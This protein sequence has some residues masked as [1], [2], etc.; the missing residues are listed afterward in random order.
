M[1]NNA[2]G[3]I[4]R[5]KDSLDVHHP[6]TLMRIIVVCVKKMFYFAEKVR[7]MEDRMGYVCTMSFE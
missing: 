4:L 2:M 5:Y 3:E 1:D 7:Q 6:D